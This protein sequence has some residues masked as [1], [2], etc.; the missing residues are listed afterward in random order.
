[1]TVWAPD[2]TNLVFE[3]HFGGS[4]ALSIVNHVTGLSTGAVTGTWSGG[5]GFMN[6]NG[7]TGPR[8]NYG[9]A[10]TQKEATLVIVVDPTGNISMLS[11]SGTNA[12]RPATARM[13]FDANPSAGTVRTINGQSITFVASGATGFQVNIGAT[14][15]A[16]AF[17]TATLINAN[18]A[19]FGCTAF[20]PVANSV[21]ELTAT[22]SGAAGNSTALA[23][24]ATPVR[25]SAAA[26]T[27]NVTAF[28]LGANGDVVTT[29]IVQS[30]GVI[31]GRNSNFGVSGLAGVAAPAAAGFYYISCVLRERDLPAIAVYTGGVPAR[32]NGPTMG[33][34]IDATAMLW[35]ALTG[36][37]TQGALIAYAAMFDGR[38]LTPAQ[39]LALH[40]A[41]KAQVIAA[42]PTVN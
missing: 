22:A 21:I 2:A 15:Q 25:F 34:P 6:L 38:A 16:T 28:S 3:H 29:G 5:A 8:F 1:M 41:V 39:D 9:F 36:A 40:N 30:S 20:C 27:S 14:P 24:G 35:S 4:E 10:R 7:N 23:G 31:Q 18:S 13:W 42:G 11:S 12:A 32:S 33:R 37:G 17:S 26:G 19:T